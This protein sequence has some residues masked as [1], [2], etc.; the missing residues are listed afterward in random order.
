MASY[1]GGTALW[2]EAFTYDTRS[3]LLQ[4]T[5]ARGVRTSF[6]YQLSGSD[7]PLNRIQSRSYDISGPLSSG[8]VVSAAPAVTYEYMTTGDKSRILKIRTAGILTEDF[9]YDSQARVSEFKQTVDGRE[10]YPWRTNYTY[11]STDRLTNVE[12]PAQYGVAG[13]PRKIV[14]HTYD[15][16]SR[17]ASLKFD[18]VEIAGTISYNTSSQ[19]T[20]IK[21]GPSG[22]NQVTENYSFD[23]QTG[24]LSGQTAVRN[25]SNLVNLIYDYGRYNSAGSANGKTGQLSKITDNL[26]SNKNREY[27]FDAL[28]RLSIAKGKASNQ[29]TQNYT[30]D[31]YGNRTNV[32][33][34]GTA[35]DGSAVPV[36]GIANLTTDA[37]TNRITAAGYE[38]DVAGNQT[39]ALAP[40]GLGVTS[41]KYEYDAANRISQVKKDDGPQT[42]VQAFNYGSTNARLIDYDALVT[43]RNTFYATV[44]GTVIAEFTEYV[45]N[46]QTWTKSNI[47]LG[48]RLLATNDANGTSAG[49]TTYHHPDRLGTKLITD[50]AGTTYE[51]AALPFGTALNAESTITTNK[52]RFTSY[53]RSAGTGLDY[54]TNRTYD[55]QI[56]RFTQVDPL[57]MGAASYSPQ[58]NNLS[59]YVQNMPTDFVDPSGLNMVAQ[60]TM[61]VCVN[62]EYNGRVCV[63]VIIHTMYSGGNLSGGNDFGGG[64]G[65]GAALSVVADNRPP[66]DD[67]FERCL[68]QKMQFL[69][70]K[71][72][73]MMNR[74]A[75]I[76]AGVTGGLGVIAPYIGLSAGGIVLSLWL[77]EFADFKANEY[78][79]ALAKAKAECKKEVGNNGSRM[80]Y[81]QVI[82]T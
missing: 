6:S 21:V 65:G 66:T 28:G 17:V 69:R 79:P 27:Q 15:V 56:G 20:S 33:A 5:D 50:A 80:Q 24:L 47:Y 22:T 46:Q 44:G 8:T 42:L 72:N 14:E 63:E 77:G 48:S 23:A 2:G 49:Y 40:A 62:T 39:K 67:K 54:A 3:N 78:D 51:Q 32:T 73:T 55:S 74:N 82:K 57:G 12:Y 41:L 9:L 29:W 13:N 25:G 43:G 45:Q 11:D 60:F 81:P 31:R 53:E 4:K 75:S 10:S 38:Y 58:S 36:D 18:A 7:D 35:A 71:L 64:R 68:R 76:W 61:T 59:A 16:T 34:S 52:Q 30:Y 70:E 19:P 26:N 37:A 1:Y